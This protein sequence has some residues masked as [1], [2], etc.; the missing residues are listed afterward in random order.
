MIFCAFKIL[1]VQPQ[2][3]GTSGDSKPWHLNT[4]QRFSGAV[5]F[6]GHFSVLDQRWSPKSWIFTNVFFN[7]EALLLVEVREKKGNNENN[8][9]RSHHLGFIWKQH[10]LPKTRLFFQSTK[11]RWFRDF[12]SWWFYL[13]FCVNPYL[14]KIPIL[15]NIFQMGWNQLAYMFLIVFNTVCFY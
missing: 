7:P 8:A 6:F 5:G 4:I 11:W 1:T 9:T 2:K 10:Q 3:K 14:G 12:T 13:F 15:T